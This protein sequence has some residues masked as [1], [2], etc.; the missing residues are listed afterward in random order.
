MKAFKDYIIPFVGLKL[1]IHQFE[2]EVGNDF[3]KLFDFEEYNSSNI[4]RTRV[5]QKEYIF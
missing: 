5:Q 4:N 3:L 2:Y 1:G